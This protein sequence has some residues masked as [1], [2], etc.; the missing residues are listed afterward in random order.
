MADPCCNIPAE[1]RAAVAASILGDPA[2]VRHTE[3]V[4]QRRRVEVFGS[5]PIVKMGAYVPAT[6][7]AAQFMLTEAHSLLAAVAVFH[8]EQSAE[9][10]RA[11]DLDEEALTLANAYLEAEEF[12]YDSVAELR[13]DDDDLFV[14]FLDVAIEARRLHAL[15]V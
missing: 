9:A 11:E 12:V 14:K 1:K 3:D 6:E 8:E 15:K 13:E 4:L 2:K 5:G 10:E 7:Q